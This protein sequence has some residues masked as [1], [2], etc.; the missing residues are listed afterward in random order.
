[1]S[2]ALARTGDRRA[3]AGLGGAAEVILA[4]QDPTGAIPWFS[5]GPWDPWNHAECVMALAVMGELD[6]AEQ[7]LDYLQNTQPDDGGWLGEYG[8]ALP[9]EGRDRIAR[10]AAPT[11]KDTNFIAYPAM[12][13]WHLYQATG[14]RAAARRRWP[15]V[16]AAIDFVLAQQH[17]Q[18][19]IS[20]CA[21]AHGLEGDDAIIAGGA[22]IYASLGSALRLADLVGDPQP[23][24]ILARERLRQALLVRPDRF[25]RGAR[26]QSAFAMDAYYP[27][28]S[29][30]MPYGGALARL[31]TRMAPFIQPGLG[32]RCVKDQPWV[33]VAESCELTIALVRLGRRA[34]AA[35]LLDWQ[36]AH[37][38]LD[39]AYW[40]GWQFEENI[41]WPLEKPTW[42]QAA[43]ILATDALN[44]ATPAWRV[45]CSG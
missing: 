11:L 37:R 43:A 44:E 24:W 18:G 3:L 14:D 23:A 15:M 40:M 34:Q 27:I 2:F 35:R 7:G 10:V 17:P 33:T 1:M 38:D 21:E 39:G 22:S 9:M 13:V 41:V 29:G 6:A 19:D 8:N 16:R 20:W 25:D 26:G 36:Q 12:A 5:G 31:E 28:L 30:V 32:C 45:L 4:A 42:T